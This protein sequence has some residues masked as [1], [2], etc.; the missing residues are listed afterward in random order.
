MNRAD[1]IKRLRTQSVE[2]PSWGF[3]ASGTRFGTFPQP[4]AAKSLE[5]KL[6]DA[7][8]AHK[9]TGILPKVALHI[10]WD[11]CDDWSKGKQLAASHGVAIGAINPNLFQQPM[12]QYGSVCH[13]DASVRAAAQAHLS[14][15]VDI[16]KATGSDALSLWFADGSNY[17]GQ[18]D[19]RARRRRMIEGLQ[20]CY[21]KL[22]AN[23]RMLIEYKFFEPAFY[24]TDLADWGSVALICHKLGPKATVLVDT[25]HHPQGTNIEWI[26]ASLLD[27]GILGGFHFNSRKYADDDL[28]VGSIN[29]HEL[30]LVYNELVAAEDDSDAG[31]RACA[32]KVAYMFDQCHSYKNPIEATI[33]SALAVQEAYAKALLVDRAALTTARNACDTVAAEE[34]LKEAYSTDVRPILKEVR[35]AMG[36]DPNPL[37]AFR[38]SGYA[39]K[40]TAERIKKYGKVASAGGGFQ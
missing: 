16:M 19:F 5:E 40:V 2:T 32:H 18:D 35:E 13:P 33:Q 15:C 11:K 10:P 26:V 28:T 7:G 9:Y 1:L 37:K 6:A 38:A 30:F 21:A 29:P 3:A 36:I 27:E 23:S 14:E 20:S 17:P 34:C 22:P 8:Q 4:W 31:V 12:Y 25:G 24:H 39:E